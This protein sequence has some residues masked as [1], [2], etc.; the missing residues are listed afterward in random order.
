MLKKHPLILLWVLLFVLLL[1]GFLWRNENSVVTPEKADALVVNSSAEEEP[2][3]KSNTENEENN[4][5]KDSSIHSLPEGDLSS[6]VSTAFPEATLPEDPLSALIRDAPMVVSDNIETEKG[7][8]RRTIYRTDF[9]YPLIR[10]LEYSE[11]KPGGEIEQRVEAVVADHVVVY[12]PLEEQ[13]VFFQQIQRTPDI[14]VRKKLD[15]GEHFLVATQTSADLNTVERITGELVRIGIPD[16]MPD[17]IAFVNKVPNDAFFYRKW[18]LHNTGIYTGLTADADID[19][20][21]A[22]EK[23]VGERSVIVAVIDSGV[24]YDHPDLK[25]NM[26]KDANGKHGYDYIEDDADPDDKTSPKNKGH[27]TH[28]AGIIGATGDNSIGVVGVCWKVQLM[29]VR[30]ISENDSGSISGIISGIRYATNNG[31]KVLNMSLGFT[32]RGAGDGDLLHRELKRARD[33]GVLVCA[34]AG[35]GGDDKIGDN[36]YRTPQYPAAYSLENI[37]TVAATD[38]NDQ[39]TEFSNYGKTSVDLAA[40]G[41][42]VY[43]AR[44]VVSQSSTGYGSA[45]GTSMSSPMVAGAVA[46]GHS[47]NPSLKYSD[48]RSILFLSVDPLRSLD[49][50]VLTGG[51]LNLHR[52]VQRVTASTIVT[53]VEDI[54]FIAG[55]GDKF[56]NPDDELALQFKVTNAGSEALEGLRAN[57]LAVSGGDFL[58][59]IKSTETI[60]D[61]DIGGSIEV[62]SGFALKIKPSANLPATVQ[63]RIDVSAANNPEKVWSEDYEFTIHSPARITGKVVR[64][65]TGLGISGAKVHYSGPIEGTVVTDAEGNFDV[66]AIA[67][68]YRIY[69]SAT[70]LIESTPADFDLPS[71]EISIGMGQIEVG[72]TPGELSLRSE[73]ERQSV[74]KVALEDTGDAEVAIN[75]SLKLSQTGGNALYAISSENIRSIFRMNPQTGAFDDEPLFTLPAGERVYSMMVDEGSIWVVTSR[76]LGVTYIMY[77][78]ETK[79]SSLLASYPITAEGLLIGIWKDSLGILI[80]TT[81]RFGTTNKVYRFDEENARVTDA[82]KAF[83]YLPGSMTALFAAGQRGSVMVVS[84]GEIWE[85]DPTTLEKKKERG[86]WLEGIDCYV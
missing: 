68:R 82:G 55:N 16:S 25:D 78:I 35:N 85:L 6:E 60:G 33:R 8:I 28:V 24:D 36:N 4:S 2:V 63:L 48:L 44:P 18:G 45:S 17:V 80:A 61:L 37:I 39:L 29:A 77:Q 79:S 11:A 41:R 7:N 72:F 73:S 13:P 53:S 75:Y 27:G 3:G 38:Y 21:E 20:P 10:V 46:L 26:W 58:E 52:F 19:A 50:K 74:A 12:I 57:L 86:Y 34:S 64:N 22:W 56:I 71:T 40:P 83:P 32:F 9:K 47:L 84:G 81:E 5:P 54:V 66:P 30:V 1:V 43:S 62:A 31:A 23:G 51:R 65:R 67:G 70:G 14:R 69:A 76:N 42:S 15:T 59:V 49:G